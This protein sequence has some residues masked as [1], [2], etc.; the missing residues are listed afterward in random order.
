MESLFSPCTRYR[1]MLESQGVEGLRGLQEID[2]NVSTEELLSA[3]RAFTYANLH[4]TLSN[5]DTV[6][7]LT[8]H[9]AVAHEGGRVEHSWLEPDES[10]C[11]SFSA[12][13]KDL[14]AF[15][16]STEHLLEICDVILRLLA[17][18][19]VHSVHLNSWNSPG[20]F[21]NA[22][23]LAYMM[24]QCQSLKVLK[25]V[26]QEMDED[27]CHVLGAY[28]RPDLEIVLDGCEITSAGTSALSE[29][30]GRNQGPTKLDY[31]GIANSIVANGLRGNSCLKSLTPRLSNSDDGNQEVLAIADGLRENEGL[32]YLE[33]IHDFTISD[34]TWDA[35]CDS[36]KTHPTLEVLDFRTTKIT[37]ALLKSRMQ[38]L[39]DMMKR[40]I[41]IHTIHLGSRLFREHKLY[42]GSVIPYLET[43]WFR[44]RLLAIQKTRPITYRAKVL[45]RALLSAPTDA[46]RFW[47]LLSGNA[48]VVFPSTTATIAA[49]GNLPTPATAAATSTAS[50]A[51]DANYVMSALTTTATGRLPI[52][53][54]D[55]TAATS[56]ATP[57]TAS[58]LD[59]FAPAVAAATVTTPSA[60]QKRKGRP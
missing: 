40:N 53:T 36:L 34:E 15:A 33:L 37:P 47:M 49:A 51:A 44:P 19:V 55:A 14:I 45:G 43:N 3:E 4:A 52:A 8:P 28:S 29:V 48:E 39:L 11:F 25:L 22:I 41:S 1:D 18:S 17:V 6:A 60:G 26:H 12:D 9:A 2:L 38:A 21:I 27:H 10:C 57:S 54:S 31:C 30:L 59:A 23:S 7:W 5:R 20:F 58:T 42:R 56:A 16:R 46:N 24:E 32:V 13:D 35:V 50:V